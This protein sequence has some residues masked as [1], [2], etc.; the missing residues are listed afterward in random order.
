MKYSWRGLICC[1]IKFS[2]YDAWEH[3]KKSYGNK[4]KTSTQAWNNKFELPDGS[5]SISDI[6]DY[7][8]YIIKN[9][10]NRPIRIYINKLENKYIHNQYRFFNL[11]KRSFE[12]YFEAPKVI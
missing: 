10:D 4:L 6:Q 8:E 7:F 3:T 2:A 9:I 1:F 12:N 11:F 5:Y